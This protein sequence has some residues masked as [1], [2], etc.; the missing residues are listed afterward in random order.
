MKIG[1]PEFVLIILLAS[2]GLL[3]RLRDPKS[4]AQW[5]ANPSEW[6][7]LVVI[8]LAMVVSFGV[9]GGLTPGLRLVFIVALGAAGAWDFV[10]RLR[11]R[12][13][14]DR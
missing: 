9:P 11:V 6:V 8:A 2:L 12:R 4:R 10:H 13:R 7:A 3:L 14:P 1:L 5:R